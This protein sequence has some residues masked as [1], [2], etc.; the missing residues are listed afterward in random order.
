[1]AGGSVVADDLPEPRTPGRAPDRDESPA[2]EQTE[3]ERPPRLL[4]T[5]ALVGAIV[6]IL[7]QLTKTWALDALADGPIHIAPTLDLALAYN[8]GTAFSLGSGQGLGPWIS[9][10]GIGVVLLLSFGETSRFRGGAWASGLIVG[11]AVG[12]LADRAFRGSDG[13]LHGAVVD[14]IAFDW[15]PTFNVADVGVTVGAVLLVI[16]GLRTT[17]A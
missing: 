9:V 5:I 14:F 16:V 17:S 12:N 15:W 11:G 4:G 2:S 7:D 8:T 13:F 1:M 6:L 10:L 3:A